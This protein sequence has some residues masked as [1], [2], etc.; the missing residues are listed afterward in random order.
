MEKKKFMSAERKSRIA[1]SILLAIGVPLLV[2]IAVPFE[3][4]CNN[5]E[6]LNYRFADIFAPFFVAFLICAVLIFSVLFFVP[7][8]LYKIF[9]GI[10]IGGAVMVFLQSN[11]LNSGVNG[12]VADGTD[13]VVNLVGK[14][15]V[16][17][18]ALI[19]F[20]VI[21]GFT[22]ASVFIKKADIVNIVSLVLALVVCVTQILNIVTPLITTDFGEGSPTARAEKLREE[23]PDYQ[24]TFLT[25]KNL[26]TFGSDRNVIVF[27][28]DRFDANY[29]EGEDKALVDEYFNR[30]GGFTYFSDHISMYGH[31]YPAATYMLTGK[32]LVWGE[33]RE[34]Y[35]KRAYQD[36]DTLK[37]LSSLEYSVNIYTDNYYGYDDAYYF[38]SYVDNAER[39]SD[40][41][42]YRDIKDKKTLALQNLKLSLYRVFPLGLKDYVGTVS[43]GWLNNQGRYTSSEL[44]APLASTDM[45]QTYNTLVKATENKQFTKDKAKN[46]SFIHISG[47]HDVPYDEDWNTAKGNDRYD[48][49]ISLTHSLNIIDK[50]ITAMKEAGVYDDA[51]I[52]ITGDHGHPVNDYATINGVRR[53]ALFVKEAG[54][55][56]SN[57]TNNKAQVSHENLWATIFKS[58]NI[59][60]DKEIFGDSIFEVNPSQNV[61]RKY[62]WHMNIS[63]VN[64]KQ[65]EYSIVGDSSKK[66]SWSL[67]KEEDKIYNLY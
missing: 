58:E 25:N 64:F 65:L 2:F 36:N 8:I 33:D 32:E 52:I 48:V 24:W 15:K 46:F 63:S 61:T 45:K 3:I 26:T 13:T 28:V 43:S 30:F 20:F 62:I 51:T 4:W 35:F 23:D 57:L 41:S 22:A 11:Y 5:I 44:T 14:T 19:W 17:I 40:E 16:I 59:D 49:T 18:N 55:K 31:T 56:E 7:Q 12:L 21:V 50:Y 9:R 66:E 6:E 37:T 42:V 39:A 29:Y 1:T 47:C 67:A 10:A 38:P 54:K 60:Y 53:T 27:V 34:D